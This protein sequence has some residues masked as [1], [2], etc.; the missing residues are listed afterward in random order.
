[1]DSI[2]YY[3]KLNI[4]SYLCV[5]SLRCVS[6][7]YKNIGNCK[8]FYINS[9]GIYY[10]A[11]EIHTSLKHELYKT[12][13]NQIKNHVSTMW[14][15]KSPLN[16]HYTNA[17]HKN[18]VLNILKP[19]KFHFCCQDTGISIDDETYFVENNNRIVKHCICLPVNLMI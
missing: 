5:H 11:C 9:E 16:I 3:T 2:D 6:K 13:I 14:Y 7:E 19:I 17:I 18:E 12:I 10:H 4:V 8:Y 15:Y 1:M